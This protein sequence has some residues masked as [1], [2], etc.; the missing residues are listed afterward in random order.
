CDVTAAPQVAGMIDGIVRH[1][2]SIDVVV[3]NAGV[4]QVGPVEHMTLA[5]FDQAMR[6][7]FWAPLYVIEAALPHMRRQRGGRIVN[8]SSIGGKV[9]VPHLVPYTASKFALAGL[10]ES[11][12]MELMSQNIFVTTVIPGLMRTGSPRNALFKGQNEKEHA[13]F[14]TGDA[15]PV[16]SI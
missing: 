2:G 5:D 1:F 7:H 10:S 15:L 11:L 3:N 4:I 9:A 6:T 14:A 8:I 12:R 13:W 16:V